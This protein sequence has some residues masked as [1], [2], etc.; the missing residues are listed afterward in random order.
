[1]DI[2]WGTRGDLQ[3]VTALAL[4][5]K[6]EGRK[7][8]VFARPPATDI[9]EANGIEFVCARENVADFIKNLFG[10]IDISDRS[11]LGLIKLGKIAKGYT[12][13][14]NYVSTQK[15][16]MELALATAREFELDLLI[17]PTA[18]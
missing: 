9:L 3:P 4:R 12:S 11:F 10:I 5:L 15:A 17:T 16:D 6:S 7:V 14:E 1:M 8:M 13:S 2:A 18:L